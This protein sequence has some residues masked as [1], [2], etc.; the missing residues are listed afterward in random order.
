MVTVP[1]EGFLRLFKIAHSGTN[2]EIETA[3]VDNNRQLD[4]SFI[5][6]RLLLTFVTESCIESNTR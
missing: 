5:R 3:D 6:F 2:T 4:L 1:G